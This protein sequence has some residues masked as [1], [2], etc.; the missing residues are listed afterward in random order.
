MSY[1]LAFC[2]TIAQ[3]M[4]H[5]NRRQLPRRK[6]RQWYL[7]S[8]QWRSLYFI[9]TRHVSALLTCSGAPPGFTQA[10]IFISLSVKNCRRLRFLPNVSKYFVDG[11][12]GRKR[13]IKMFLNPLSLVQIN[14]L[15][16]EYEKV[17]AEAPK[18]ILMPRKNVLLFLV[19]SN[20]TNST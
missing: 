1:R 6:W 16:T 2:K 17:M 8:V 14:D 9:F 10:A 20:H 7:S 12:I 19:L 18:L 4:S 5:N 11:T 13:L 3:L 15:H